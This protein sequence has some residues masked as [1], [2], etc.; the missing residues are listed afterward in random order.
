[1]VK[2][3]KRQT[4]Y[5]WDMAEYFYVNDQLPSCA[6]AAELVGATPN[7][8]GE[9]YVRLAKM[10]FIEKNEAGH[11]RRGPKWPFEAYHQKPFIEL[12]RGD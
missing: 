8:G 12:K 1:M 4:Q 2:L 6:K 10:G 11:Y 5:L 9:M 3:T 7:A